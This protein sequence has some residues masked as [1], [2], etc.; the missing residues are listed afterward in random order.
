MINIA[1]WMYIKDSCTHEHH[2]K[3]LFQNSTRFPKVCGLKSLAV[4]NSHIQNPS[5]NNK[6]TRRYLITVSALLTLICSQGLK[7]K[8]TKSK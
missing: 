3:Q 1:M 6:I 8:A 4:L 5:P 2:V 7:D